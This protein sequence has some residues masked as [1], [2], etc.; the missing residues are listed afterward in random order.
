MFIIKSYVKYPKKDITNLNDIEKN[1]FYYFIDINNVEEILRIQDQL[2]HNYIDG[3]LYLTYKK[4]VIIDFTYWDLIDHLW[5]YILNMIEDFLENKKITTMGFPDTAIEMKMKYLNDCYMIFSIYRGTL[6]E[7]K[8]PQYEFLQALLIG[9]KHFFEKAILSIQRNS[10]YYRIELK[11][12]EQLE[13][14]INA[15]KS[16]EKHI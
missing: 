6:L 12:I 3:V 4:K 16:Y 13:P 2:D 8:L 1:P 7:L 14:K 5:A 10:N 15:L 11:R 9:A